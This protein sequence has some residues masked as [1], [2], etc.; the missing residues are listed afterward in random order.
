MERLFEAYVRKLRGFLQAR[1]Q[2]EFYERFKNVE[3]GG[4]ETAS[5]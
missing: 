3:T 1:D 2:A 4:K 5:A